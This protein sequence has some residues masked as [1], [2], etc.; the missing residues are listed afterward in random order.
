[1]R[2]EYHYIRHPRYRPDA[3]VPPVASESAEGR[4]DNEEEEGQP[5]EDE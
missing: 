2:G 5:E 1:M 4:R 3:A